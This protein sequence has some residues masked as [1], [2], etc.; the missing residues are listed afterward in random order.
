MRIEPLGDPARMK[1][2]KQSFM[3]DHNEPCKQYEE[4]F[5]QAAVEFLNKSG[6][7]ETAA[8]ELGV[9]PAEL[10]AW[11]RKKSP[12]CKPAKNLSGMARLRAENEALRNQVLSLQIQWDILKTTLGMLSTTVGTR[13]PR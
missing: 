5:K 10:R 13:E 1:T 12:R 3:A 8:S 7:L 11:K 2:R 4:T 9:D 6:S